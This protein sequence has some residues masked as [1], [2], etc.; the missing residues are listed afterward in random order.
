MNTLLDQ[1]S[2][3]WNVLF[4]DPMHFVLLS[5]T[6]LGLAS[7]YC[8]IKSILR[9]KTTTGVSLV[10]IMVS[11]YGLYLA[12]SYAEYNQDSLMRACTILSSVALIILS[13]VVCLGTLRC[14]RPGDFRLENYVE[15]IAAAFLFAA[16]EAVWFYFDRWPEE[17]RIAFAAS[18]YRGFAI[19]Q[20]VI[21][22][23]QVYKLRRNAR[24]RKGTGGA[25]LGRI[26]L[27]LIALVEMTIYAGVKGLWTQFFVVLF[28]SIVQLFI[29][30][31]FFKAKKSTKK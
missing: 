9:E 18:A 2:L 11:T 19:L 20:A 17:E 26:V 6:A 21:A 25:S 4:P 13:I 28:P 23:H 12:T 29:L 24:L 14:S 15:F 16:K 27:M 10:H 30:H 22:F 3:I 8:E 31:A 7:I 5:A 1:A